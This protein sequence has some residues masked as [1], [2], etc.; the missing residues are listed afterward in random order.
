MV[1]ASSS[2]HTISSFSSWFCRLAITTRES[3][4]CVDDMMMGRAFVLIIAFFHPNFSSN[5]AS[6]GYP[7]RISLLPISVTR[8]HITLSMPLVVTLSLREWVI[9]P[10]LLLVLSMLYIHLGLSSRVIANPN[11]FAK[12]GWMKLSVAPEST[13]AFLLAMK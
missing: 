13:S 2:L 8:N 5:V 9:L 1:V 10:A 3:T 11:L 4:G 6:Q 12:A 7:R